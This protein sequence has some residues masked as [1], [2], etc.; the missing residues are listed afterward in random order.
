MNAAL[1]D[2]A[3]KFTE[4]FAASLADKGVTN[5]EVYLSQNDGTLMTMEHARRY[6]SSPSRAGRDSIRGA[7]YLSRR[8]D[9]HRHR[10]GRHH[11]PGRS[12][13]GFPREAAWR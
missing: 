4:G 7:S 9:R 1:Y 10:R 2:V 11:R 3:R 12:V 6:P 5:A 13:H 8:D